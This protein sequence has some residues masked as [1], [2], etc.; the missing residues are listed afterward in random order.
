MLD[1]LC[2]TMDRGFVVSKANPLRLCVFACGISTAPPNAEQLIKYSNPFNLENGD[3]EQDDDDGDR[4]TANQRPT[5][6]K[7]LCT[8][9]RAVEIAAEAFTRFNTHL[10]A[11]IILDR[12]WTSL[13]GSMPT[14]CKVLRKVEQDPKDLYKIGI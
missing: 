13:P 9:V 4:T 8:L 12:V 11:S 6:G 1:N 14:L 7:L 10:D 3:D 5:R 2:S